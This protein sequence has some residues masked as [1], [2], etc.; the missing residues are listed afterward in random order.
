MYVTFL[1]NQ[2]IHLIVMIQTIVLLWLIGA[3]LLVDKDTVNTD[4]LIFRFY[5]Q[6]F[7]LILSQFV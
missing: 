7:S 5:V 2:L 1:Y 4:R 6:H 3:N